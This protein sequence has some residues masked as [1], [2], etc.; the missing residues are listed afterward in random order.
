MRVLSKAQFP[1]HFSL[2]ENSSKGYNWSLFSQWLPLL[3]ISSN[4][5]VVLS[6]QRLILNTLRLTFNL[7]LKWSE[8]TLGRGGVKSLSWV[9]PGPCFVWIYT[10]INWHWVWGRRERSL[11]HLILKICMKTHLRTFLE[12]NLWWAESLILIK[13]THDDL[14]NSRTLSAIENVP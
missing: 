1:S 3:N 13:L 9:R 12:N 10:T 14:R 7:I 8:V 11:N 5:P 6:H 4:E 2:F